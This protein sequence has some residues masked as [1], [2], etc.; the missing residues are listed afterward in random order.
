MYENVWTIIAPDEAVSFGIIKP[1][2]GALHF[3]SLLNGDFEI[4]LRSAR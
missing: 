2:H 1:L 3:D 4:S